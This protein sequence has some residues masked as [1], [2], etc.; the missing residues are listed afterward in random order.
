MKGLKSGL[1]LSPFFHNPLATEDRFLNVVS[2][3]GVNIA[4]VSV[5]AIRFDPTHPYRFSVCGLP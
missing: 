2:V 3:C 5:S 4:P 1:F